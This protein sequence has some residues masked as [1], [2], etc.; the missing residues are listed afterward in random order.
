MN[1]GALREVVRRARGRVLRAMAA[2]LP[3]AVVFQNGSRGVRRVALTFDDG[4][5]ALSLRFF[6]A[7]EAAGAASRR[8]VLTVT[9][10][11]PAP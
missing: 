11:N 5:G 6:D 3:T 2:P 8:S 10:S 4:P 9:S 1:G 7:L